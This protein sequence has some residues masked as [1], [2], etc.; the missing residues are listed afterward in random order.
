[1]H[2]PTGTLMCTVIWLPG[3]ASPSRLRSW[4][5]FFT[6]SLCFWSHFHS[7]GS[8]KHP[9]RRAGYLAPRNCKSKSRPSSS[10]YFIFSWVMI[11]FSFFKFDFFWVH[12]QV[13]P[14]DF[15]LSFSFALLSWRFPTK[16]V[17]FG[18]RW[19]AF[20]FFDA[21]CF[22]CKAFFKTF[23]GL[24]AKKPWCERQTTTNS[25]GFSVPSFDSQ[26]M[27]ALTPLCLEHFSAPREL[28]I[29]KWVNLLQP[30]QSQGSEVR[31]VI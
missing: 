31:F 19:T 27:C 7:L 29:F 25:K 28:K 15:S 17:H 6:S 1:M 14:D 4:Q 18:H 16:L 30:F 8:A 22:P 2:V 12:A 24:P 20:K 5:A 21:R 13:F 10:M 26:W 3:C 11:W 23:N 9:K